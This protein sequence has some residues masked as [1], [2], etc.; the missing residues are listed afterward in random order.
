MKHLIHIIFLS[1]SFNSPA[2]E[3]DFKNLGEIN[4]K[5][6]AQEFFINNLVEKDT[7]L[8]YTSRYEGLTN[9]E[10]FLKYKST[11]NV[12]MKD[13]TEMDLRKKFYYE[14]DETKIIGKIFSIDIYS[15]SYE[16]YYYENLRFTNFDL[17]SDLNNESTSVIAYNHNENENEYYKFISSYKK[18]Y[19][20]FKTHNNKE[21]F[22]YIFK[23]E[24]NTVIIKKYKSSYREIDDSA[25]K[26][27]GEIEEVR[28]KTV[29]IK[30]FIL[31]NNLNDNQTKFI[32]QL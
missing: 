29:N 30:I 7:I 1:F 10:Y 8:S 15:L 16:P 31:S 5:T 18:K 12:S 21:T 3:N 23:S 4:D 9:T 2:Q 25:T 28:V 14:G 24:R 32:L 26:V 20:N 13:V 6:N 17:F 22:D 11:G 27:E 19:P